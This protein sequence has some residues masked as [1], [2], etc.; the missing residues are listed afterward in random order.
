MLCPAFSYIG[1]RCLPISYAVQDKGH[2]KGHLI[3]LPFESQ[4]F[5]KSKEVQGEE[6]PVRHIIERNE[7]YYHGMMYA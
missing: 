2:L 4:T 7:R 5:Y 6:V 1:I 3:S